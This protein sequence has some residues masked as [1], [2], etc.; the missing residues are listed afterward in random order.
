[1]KKIGFIGGKFLPFHKGHEQAIITASKQVEKL[2]VILSSSEKRDKELCEASHINYIP[3]ETR[4]AWLGYTFAGYHNIIVRNVIDKDSETDYDWDKGAELIK[5]T[6]EEK[7][8][9]VFSSEH[10]Y[11]VYFKKNFPDAEHIVI[12]AERSRVPISATR[13]RKNIYK[14][15]NFLPVIVQTYFAIKVALVGIDST[16]KSTLCQKLANV[17]DC[18]WV[19]EVG[20]E[21]TEKY[22]NNFTA[23]M[24]DLIAIEQFSE[25]EKVRFMASPFVFID[26]EAVITQYYLKEYHYKESV[27]IEALIKRQDIDL[28]IYMEPDIPWVADGYRLHRTTEERKVKNVELKQMFTDRDIEI[29]PIYGD[30]EERLEKACDVL[31][32]YLK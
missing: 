23:S 6:I 19:P 31:D 3:Q 21:M 12:D 5:D 18:P 14:Y 4:M 17:Y 8:D 16:G 26:S 10:E 27:F 22:N 20:R 13:I 1:M 30:F 32:N 11:D 28:Y 2:Y 7:I 25:T 15:W 9:V 29:I 24:F